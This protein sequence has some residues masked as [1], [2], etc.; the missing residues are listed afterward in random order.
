MLV[1]GIIAQRANWWE[2]ENLSRQRVQKMMAK[3]T[4]RD[5]V[6]VL[7]ATGFAK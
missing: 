4:L 7:D 5:G 6:L 3:A 1:Q 2:E